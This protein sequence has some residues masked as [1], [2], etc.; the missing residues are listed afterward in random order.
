MSMTDEDVQTTIEYLL[1]NLP[2]WM[3]EKIE[4]VQSLKKQFEERGSLTE[5]QQEALNAAYEK[6]LEGGYER[7]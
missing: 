6:L 7:G 5:R 1:G 2:E 3:T 4:F